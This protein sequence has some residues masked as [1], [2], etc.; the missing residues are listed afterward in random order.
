MRFWEIFKFLITGLL[1]AVLSIL[2]REI[3]YYW[4]DRKKRP[5]KRKLVG[6]WA[7]FHYVFEG[8]RVSPTYTIFI[9]REVLFGKIRINEIRKENL[10]Y[11]GK[12]SLEDK[13]ILINLVEEECE[14]HVFIRIF[15]FLKNSTYG[16]VSCWDFNQKPMAGPII[17][18]RISTKTDHETAKKLNPKDHIS[19]RDIKHVLDN[20]RSERKLGI[21]GVDYKELPNE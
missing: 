13:Y 14:E 11:K 19:D 16:I 18:R 4:K 5:Y 6:I 1:G 10:L 3:I 7:V 20:S 17:M 21:V 8:N 15:K 12:L 2:I 9:I